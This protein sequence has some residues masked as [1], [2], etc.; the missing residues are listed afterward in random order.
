MHT[1]I[2]WYLRVLPVGHRPDEIDIGIAMNLVTKS[3]L[4]IFQ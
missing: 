3:D 1:S 2:W 4:Q